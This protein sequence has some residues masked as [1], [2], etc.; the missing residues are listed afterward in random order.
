MKIAFLN[1]YQNK[2]N[3]G[4]ETFVVELS[5]RLSKNHEVDIISDIKYLDLFKTRY[6]LVIPTNGR[7]QSFLVRIITWLT[8][9]KMFIS[10]QS[11]VGFDDRLNLYSMPDRFVA[12]SSYA[13][14][15][16]IK[17]NP[18]VKSVYIPNGVDL[19]KFNTKNKK[20]NKN[21][22]TIVSVGAFTNEKRHNL[23]IDAVSKLD[24]VKLIIVG[25]GGD[26]KQD[27]SDLGLKSLGKDRF[28]V[29]KTSNDKM[30][31]I[32]SRSDLF[33]FPTVPWESFGIVL[34]EAMASNLPVVATDDPI[35]REIVGNAGLFVDPTDTDAYAKTIQKALD[36]DWGDKPRKQ[37]EKFDW[38]KIAKQY[39]ELFNSL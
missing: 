5:K 35:R 25:G 6:D 15:K 2:V 1:R 19:D 17:R 36:I 22:K 7:I 37:A 23:T 33:V 24:N 16:S 3:R 20:Q 26:L 18:F 27:I 30:P 11:G 13:L 31:E 9:S 14:Q 34:V 21:I 28:E 39:E 32:Y 8:G 4:A 12:L 29:F 38:D 10:G